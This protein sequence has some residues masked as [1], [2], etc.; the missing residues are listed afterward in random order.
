MLCCRVGVGFA[1]INVLS[2]GHFSFFKAKQFY[3]IL[4]HAFLLARHAC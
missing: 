4:A 3:R 2:G 1:V